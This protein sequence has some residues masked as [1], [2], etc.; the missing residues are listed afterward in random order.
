MTRP[1]TGAPRLESRPPQ[2]YL[3]VTASVTMTTIAQIADRIPE[4]IATVTGRGVPLAGAPFLRYQVIDMAGELVIA[5]GVPV[6]PGTGPIDG[7]AGDTLPG[8]R[9]A[10]VVHHGP[11]DRLVDATAELLAWADGRDLAFDVRQTPAGE[12]WGCRLES[13]LSNPAEVPDPNDWDTEL[14]FRLAG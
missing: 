11:P 6:A 13:Y 2:A 1:T 10:V 14:A 4:V 8:G 3:G 12:A 9:Y 5:A 7:L